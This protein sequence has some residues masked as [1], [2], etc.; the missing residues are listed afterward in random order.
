VGVLSSLHLNGNNAGLLARP[1]ADVGAAMPPL[2]RPQRL[3]HC[4]RPRRLPPPAAPSCS[5][6]QAISVFPAGVDG[7][8][9]PVGRVGVGLA[10]RQLG[11]L[12][13]NQALAALH[14]RRG[15]GRV[16]ELAGKRGQRG[17]AV[18][19]QAMAARAVPL[20]NSSSRTAA[21]GSAAARKSLALAC[22]CRQ[23]APAGGSSSGSSR[24]AHRGDVIVCQLLAVCHALAG[25]NQLKVLPLLQAGRQRQWP[26]QLACAVSRRRQRQACGLLT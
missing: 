20:P 25:I 10:Q 13:G 23:A 18:E 2:H 21:V 14:S 11:T 3:N 1:P 16:C 24:G 22:A 5:C 8:S 12:N 6:C 4:H 19:R 15:V 7:G 26:Q 17:Q 9:V